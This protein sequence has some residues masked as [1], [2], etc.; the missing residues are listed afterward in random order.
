MYVVTLWILKSRI[1]KEYR[2]GCRS[3]V[4]F[5]IQ[6]CKTADGL[7][8]CLCKTC[9]LK[10]QHTPG[11]VY[12]HLTGGEECDPNIKIGFITARGLYELQ[13]KALI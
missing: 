9:R 6:N 11:V 8:F 5:A 1:S 2:D 3:F 13:L 7:I 4:D 10:R 12:D